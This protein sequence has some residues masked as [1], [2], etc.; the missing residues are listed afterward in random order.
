MSPNPTNPGRLTPSVS[1]KRVGRFLKLDYQLLDANGR[2][3]T[4]DARSS[5]PQF[6]IYQGDQKIGSG[7]FEYG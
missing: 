4:V 1:V 5:Q 7:S 6:T 2:K 3:Y